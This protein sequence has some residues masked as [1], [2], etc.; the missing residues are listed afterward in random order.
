MGMKETI[1]AYIS[2]SSNISNIG[3][4]NSWQMRVGT[5]LENAIN[6]DTAIQF[7]QLGKTVLA[8]D[9]FPS[10]IGFLEALSHNA[11][12][13]L[14]NSTN[15]PNIANR[16][17]HQNKKVFVV[18]GHDNEAK[19]TVSRFI[20]KIGLKAIVLHEQA[21][22]GFT[23]VEKFERHANVSFAVVL[24]TPDDKGHPVSD[25][26]NTRFRARQN[27]VLE[28]GYFM[29]SLG[30]HRVCALHKGNIEIPSDF[31][32]VLYVEMDDRGAWK[33]EL[34]QEFVQANIAIDLS[35][36]L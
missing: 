11:E 31:Q 23:V 36:L 28:L 9:G 26:E 12:I 10:Q 17:P 21:N 2:D 15:T 20:D 19:E 22:E 24:L 30:R 4:L 7:H 13:N 14:S 3:Q 8:F 34:A 32:G 29:G 25:P 35:G 18:H 1:D 6:S 33:S 27:V 5:F 16:T